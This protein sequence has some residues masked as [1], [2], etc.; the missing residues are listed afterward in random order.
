MKRS[1]D[2]GPQPAV[3]NYKKQRFSPQ[4]P[5]GYP[6]GASPPGGFNQN[7]A[8]LYG[9]FGSMGPYVNVLSGMGGMAGLGSPP[10]QASASQG[11]GPYQGMNPNQYQ[12][13]F[14]QSGSY[15]QFPSTAFHTSQHYQAASHAFNQTMRTIYLGN[16]P[17]LV[18]YEEVINIVKGGSLEQVKILEEKNCAFV[19]FV[20]ATAA[21]AF[22]ADSQAKRPHIGTQEIKVGWGK[23]STIPPTILAA[24]QGGASRNVFIGNIDEGVTEPMLTQEFGRFGPV[25]QIKILFEKRIAFVHMASIAAAMKAVS[26]LPNDSRWANRRINYGKDRCAYQPKV[27]GLVQNMGFGMTFDPFNGLSGQMNGNAGTNRTVYLGS[28]HP[29]VTTKDLCDVIRGGILQNIKYMPDKNIAF[30]TFIDPSSA[31][32]FYNRGTY[33]GVV[34]KGKR[35]KVG[36]GKATSL[37]QSVAVAVQSGASRN[38][39]IGA[40][41][42]LITEDRLRKDFSE[43]GD[44]ELVNIIPE[45][46]IGF[47]NFVDIMSAVKAVE[48]MKLVPDYG[49]YKINY[50]KDRCGNPP[51]PP[52]ESAV[53]R[54]AAVAAAAAAGP[55]N[56]NGYGG[57]K[58]STGG[59]GLSAMEETESLLNGTSLLGSSGSFL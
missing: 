57:D 31:V 26:T 55:A 56:E 48:S 22:H 19:T 6:L 29:D 42:E 58:V 5:Y 50:G 3:D 23:H 45:K 51:R 44:I 24:I 47:V 34:L 32:N 9:Q 41:D 4:T 11:L 35:L 17:P 2:Y 37:P 36:W 59:M 7:N 21:H 14:S 15:N 38:V 18:S 53:Q 20:E 12:T 52:R 10:P 13:Q 49:K 54:A 40:I 25:D 28:I 8:D 43:F 33:E 27:A 30:V 39:Y 16:L 46:N 1:N